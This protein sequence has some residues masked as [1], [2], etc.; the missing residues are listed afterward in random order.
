M[1]MLTHKLRM[2]VRTKH[3]HDALCTALETSRLLYNAALEERIGAWSKVK[4][5]IARLEAQS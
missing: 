2:T 3:Q 1:V 5:P 4:L